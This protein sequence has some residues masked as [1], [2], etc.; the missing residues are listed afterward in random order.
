VVNFIWVVSYHLLG[1]TGRM[2]IHSV[3]EDMRSVR[4]MF[5]NVPDAPESGAGVYRW[6]EP[7]YV[8]GPTPFSPTGPVSYEA[9]SRLLH[10]FEVV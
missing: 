10:T 6:E 7:E 8:G 4:R 9:V 5:P 3:H 1:R 2:M